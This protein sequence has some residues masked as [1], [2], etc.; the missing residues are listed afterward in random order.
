MK[1]SLNA[2]MLEQKATNVLIKESPKVQAIQKRGYDSV[3]AM[4]TKLTNAAGKLMGGLYS[5]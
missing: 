1:K 2:K 4:K 3:K 5:K